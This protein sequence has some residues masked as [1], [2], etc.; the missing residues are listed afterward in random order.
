MI[1]SMTGYG[2]GEVTKDGSSI[3]VELRSLNNRYFDLN[4]RTPSSIRDK[5]A[6]IRNLLNEKL[7]RG[8]VD[9][10]ITIENGEEARISFNK[11]LVKKYY[12]ELK[13][14]SKELD[15]GKRDLLS[16]AMQMPEVMNVQ[17]S[18]TDD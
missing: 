1:K 2:K 17:K 13:L 11:E 6:E 3:K 18:E 15:S 10:T 16:L 5:E 9:V 8:K 14:L 4:L 7:Q 12:A